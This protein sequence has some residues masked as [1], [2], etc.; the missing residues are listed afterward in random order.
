MAEEKTD[1]SQSIELPA[2]ML[3]ALGQDDHGGD[4]N[5]GTGSMM[6]LDL[7]PIDLH[8]PQLRILEQPKSVG[9]TFR[10]NASACSR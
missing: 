8:E 7:N 5:M 6:D 9:E 2:G 10:F 4:V 3:N 1:S